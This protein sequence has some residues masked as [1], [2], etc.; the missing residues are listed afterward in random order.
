MKIGFVGL[1]KMGKAIVLHLLEEGLDVVVYNR[2]QQ[3]VQDLQKEYEK[4]RIKNSEARIMGK[5]KKYFP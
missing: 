4:T 2:T 5:R 3:K 1:G